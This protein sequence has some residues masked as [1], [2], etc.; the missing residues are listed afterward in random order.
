MTWQLRCH[1]CCCVVRNLV[2]SS[3]DVGRGVTAMEDCI[4]KLAQTTTGH[5]VAASN[6]APLEALCPTC[7]DVVVLRQRRLMNN[8]GIS[9]F[10]R[11]LRN[12]N[13]RCEARV[14]PF[15]LK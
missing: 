15:L 1:T 9:Y 5:P 4:M 14:Y 8:A 3:R 13:L 12:R 11:H 7:G 6:L 10:W 2:R